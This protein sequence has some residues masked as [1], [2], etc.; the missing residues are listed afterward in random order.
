MG[1]KSG[2]TGVG[3]F[4]RNLGAGGSGVGGDSTN[5]HGVT[6]RSTNY[7]GVYGETARSDN[8]YGIYTPDN[9]YSLNYH[10]MGAIMQ[11]AQNGGDV[12]LQP[13]D[14][15]IFSGVAAPLEDGSPAVIQVTQATE[16]SSP[17]VAGVV[18]ARL[19]IEAVTGTEDVLGDPSRSGMEVILPGSVAPGEYLL[20]IVQG[21]AQ[22]LASAAGGPIQPGDLLTS[23]ATAGMAARAGQIT[24]EGVTMAAPG[25]VFGKA[26]EALPAGDGLIYV[27]V[28][29]Q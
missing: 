26:L 9:L 2:N 15:V 10:L 23:A 21:P 13:G 7:R 4:G 18:S 6:G 11:V 14:V 3:V 25:T 27:Y 20:L 22:V 5:W 24:V 12:A 17:A 8:N 1:L 28:T 29:L 16:A 19:A